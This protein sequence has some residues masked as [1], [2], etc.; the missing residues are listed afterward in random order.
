MS[1]ERLRLVLR[2][3]AAGSAFGAMAIS[4][5]VPLWTVALFAVALV[6]AVAGRR[7]LADGRLSAVA[8]LVAVVILYAAVMVEQLDLVVAACTTASLLT[9]QRM[10]S[11]PTARTTDQVHLASLLMIAGGAVLSADLLFALCLFLYAVLAVLSQGLS[12]LAEAGGGPFPP[13]GRV[14]RPLAAG[15]T[16]SMA[17]ALAFFV[18]FPRL[19]WNVAARRGGP[20][21][22][23][24]TTGFADGLR[25][26]GTGLLKSNPRVVFRA[27]IDPD[28]G[29]EQLDAYWVGR[30]FDVFDG[31]QWS[32]SGRP[33]APARQVVLGSAEPNLVRQEID[34]LPAYGSR[35]LVA[36]DAPVIFGDA[37][38]HQATFSV[39]TELVPSGDRE[40]RL[41]GPSEH[42]TYR[43]F[44]A[45][46]RAV[47]RATGD[48]ERAR[49]LQLPARLDPRIP[50]LASTLSEGAVGDRA[51]ARQL[52]RA[53]QSGYAYTLEL[54]G[55]VKDPLADFFFDRRAGHC[56]DFATALAVL[57]RSRQ[58]PAR[59]VVGFHGG[60]RAA[61][62][63]LIRAGDAHAWVEAEVDGHVLRLD[64][65]PPQHRSAAGSGVTGWLLA[66]W[67]ALQIRWLDR[68]VEYSLSD[69]ARLAQGIQW[70]TGESHA[71]P[72]ARRP[73]GSVAVALGILAA[74]FLLAA[75]L[76]RRAAAGD[77]AAL[78]RTLHRLLRRRGRLGPAGWLD[79]ARVE[80]AELAPVREGIERYREAR[81]GR[82]PL[83]PGERRRLVRQA[84][85]ALRSDASP[86]APRPSPP[87]SRA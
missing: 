43:A 79:G 57:L 50:A 10:L 46:D 78:G 1:P 73:D 12:V 52:E 17:G 54:P 29:S 14:L 51:V 53:L 33:G 69:Q 30:R 70:K 41:V 6:V 26:G 22:G 21:L 60:E 20:S 80:E 37:E 86:S 13:V 64:A 16:L 23:A 76:G 63:Y 74:A 75:L 84:R 42:L 48:G 82:R 59:V 81:F 72:T 4:A 44:S 71:S 7:P 62:E 45:T 27:R 65:T 56:E 5:Q 8:L 32:A 58:I 40:V 25:L 66:R 3:L 67:E 34:L 11:R 9:A 2:D 83:G 15:V 19:S 77:A 85:Q 47:L 55:R 61:G 18:L 35:T 24:A 39:R 28:P 31:V 38:S 49:R 36:L 87:T 68:V